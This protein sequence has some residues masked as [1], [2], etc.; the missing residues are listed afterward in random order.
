M[1]LTVVH[2]KSRHA[3]TLVDPC[4]VHG[5]NTHTMTLGVVHYMVCVKNTHA[6]TLVDQC[7]VCIEEHT[8]N[9]SS[10]GS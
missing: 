7:V 1:N 6:M 3:M 4:V 9:D 8:S 5:K 10:C 2:E